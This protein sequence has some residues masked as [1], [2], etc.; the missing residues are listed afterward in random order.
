MFPPSTTRHSKRTAPLPTSTNTIPLKKLG[1]SVPYLGDR[2]CKLQCKD[3]LQKA[4]RGVAQAL[5]LAAAYED[6]LETQAVRVVE[7]V[8]E[9]VCEE[10]V[11]QCCRIRSQRP[12]ANQPP[13]ELH[14][15]L[16][17]LSTL[18]KDEFTLRE[19]HEGLWGA[20]VVRGPIRQ[21]THWAALCFLGRTLS[22][23]TEHLADSALEDIYEAEVLLRR[24]QRGG[25]K[26]LHVSKGKKRVLSRSVGK[27]HALSLLKSKGEGMSDKLYR[28]L[29]ELLFLNGFVGPR[30]QHQDS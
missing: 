14:G 9:L 17:S 10:S 3:L 21:K 16:R 8:L 25:G 2:S 22:V 5:V 6:K 24:D 7:Q 1:Y 19:L 11:V 28:D 20:Q 29:E 27:G 18:L 30:H 15:A 26:A 23:L 4:F 12:C 13:T